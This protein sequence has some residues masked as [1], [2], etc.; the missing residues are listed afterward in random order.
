MR[1]LPGVT[2]IQFDNPSQTFV[3]VLG[4]D[5]KSGAIAATVKAQGYE[6]TLLDALPTV[7]R[8]LPVARLEKSTSSAIQA[9]LGR[10]TARNVRLVIAFTGSFCP[11]CDAFEKET[12]TDPRV[13]DALENKS[14][15]LHIDIAKD[16]AAVKQFGVGLVPDVWFF[17]SDGRRLG[18]ETRAL[19]AEALLGALAQYKNP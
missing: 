14:E 9:A 11:S 6:P 13:R 15:F 18:R 3:V 2:G 7:E 16:P 10:A 4:P 5:A 8:P 17:A 19:D 1:V 12:L